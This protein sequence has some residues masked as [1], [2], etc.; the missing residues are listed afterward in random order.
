MI[1]NRAKLHYPGTTTR[2]IRQT[3]GQCFST[4]PCNSARLPRASKSQTEWPNP[5]AN[6]R[7]ARRVITRT[8]L[9]LNRRSRAVWSSCQ[10]DSYPCE[11]HHPPSNMK[12]QALMMQLALEAIQISSL[13]VSAR[14]VLVQLL[15]VDSKTFN[16]NKTKNLSG[17]SADSWC[18]KSK[19]SRTFKKRKV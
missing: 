2:T 5:S 13:A 7:S 14:L 9:K 15:N 3:Y 16:S 19:T 4:N 18:N 12:S 8:I 11:T 1:K 6:S 17:G 10:T